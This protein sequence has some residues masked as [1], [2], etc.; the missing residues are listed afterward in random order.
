MKI[1]ESTPEE[2]TNGQTSFLE[3]YCGSAILAGGAVRDHLLDRTIRDYDFFIEDR[4]GLYS[5]LRQLGFDHL[6]ED[7]GRRSY[8]DPNIRYV[9]KNGN[10]DV[11]VVSTDPR[12]HVTNRFTVNICKVYATFDSTGDVTAIY[13]SDYFT[14]G[15]QSRR[16]TVDMNAHL[17]PH[18]FETY[19]RKL[20]AKFPDFTVV[21]GNF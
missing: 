10:F 11:V 1:N 6:R 20:A 15:V 13:E 7:G 18:F 9:L 21:L 2:T 3:A 12:D 14:L 4:V 17:T 5:E 19:I 16:I 8:D